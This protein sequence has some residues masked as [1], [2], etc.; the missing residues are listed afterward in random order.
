MQYLTN[1]SDQSN[2]G[3]SFS[4]SSELTCSSIVPNLIS[5]DKSPAK[6]KSEFSDGSTVNQRSES[7]EYRKVPCVVSSLPRFVHLHF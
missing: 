2:E 7:E 4:I 1:T 3:C 5:I 6:F